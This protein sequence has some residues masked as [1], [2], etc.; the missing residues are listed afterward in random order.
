MDGDGSFKTLIPLFV[1]AAVLVVFSLIFSASESAFLSLNKLRVR[2]L[3]DQKVKKALR[4]GLLLDKKEELLN[5]LLVANNIVNIMLSA[6]LTAT[7]LTLFGKKGVGIATAVTTVLL[8]IFGEITPKTIATRHPEKIAYAFAP[9]ISD[10]MVVL[11]PI[12]IIFTVISRTVLKILKLDT[13]KKTVSFTEE[14][15][16]TFIDIGEEEGVIENNEK[17]M[18]RK[19]FKFSDLA[20]VDV[21]IPR[22]QIVSV[23]VN[24]AY[25]EL[26]QLSEKTHIS[27]FP[28]IKNGIDDIVGMLYIRDLLQYEI[29]GGEFDVSKYMKEPVFVPGTIKMSSIQ[30]TLRENNQSIAIVVDEYSGTDGMI[31]TE[32]ISKEIFGSIMENNVGYGRKPEV[33]LEYSGVSL[34]E[35]TTRLIDLEE[36][37]HIKLESHGNE[38]IAGFL[39]ERLD[40]IPSVGDFVFE[41]GFI[42]KVT[43]MDGVRV[44]KVSCEQEEGEK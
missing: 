42:F 39:C 17:S 21:M 5:T 20:A 7:A 28:V 35:G 22:T 19:V 43:E 4:V 26:L 37:L 36:V 10:L 31:T 8:L 29:D 11:K 6:I 14:E 32:D 30:Q 41:G 25:G 18:M 44:A 33:N 34:L 13:K 24:V 27:R 2:L 15:I 40:K 16:K 3:R 12:V 1:S 23:S 38:T 9:F